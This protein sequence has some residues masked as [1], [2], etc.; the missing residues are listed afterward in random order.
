MKSVIG[1][2]RK[3]KQNIKCFKINNNIID[4]DL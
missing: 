1:N 3:T 4:N 2:K